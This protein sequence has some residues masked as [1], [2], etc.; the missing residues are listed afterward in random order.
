MSL[1]DVT[2]L[3]VTS[4]DAPSPAEDA[5]RS[6][7]EWAR[8]RGVHLE[9]PR[10]SHALGLQA[11]PSVADRVEEGLEQ[12]KDAV[13]ALDTDGAEQALAS[14]EGLVRAH[15]ELP[16]AGWLLA[17]VLRG[18]ATRWQRLTPKDPARALEAWTRAAALDGGR[19]SGVGDVASSAHPAAVLA[20]L[21]LDGEGEA[22]LDGV[23]VKEGAL[24]T[25]EGDHQLTVTR[26]GRLVWAAWVTLGEGTLVRVAVPGAPAC[27]REDLAS[28]HVIEG[29]L[30]SDKV[31]CPS[32]VLA[33]PIRSASGALGG[34][35]LTMCEA[36]HCGTSVR[37]S[38]GWVEGHPH[39]PDK[40]A[41]HWPVWATWVLAGAGVAAATGVTLAAAG[42]FR[43][44]HDEP[45]FTTGGLHTTSLPIHLDLAAPRLHMP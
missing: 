33:E 45:V 8:A 19:A 23:P 27:S 42:V 17:E 25:A 4:P 22:R 16:Q 37:W 38:V 10:V 24:H 31:R 35:A 3:W 34:L 1:P 40:T 6:L 26:D 29:H 30:A 39:G 44:V 2:V 14:A 18:W 11:D 9:Q 5:Q 13:I 43:P 41:R 36:D 20:R 21:V 7:L 28:A 15:P 12:A 32:W